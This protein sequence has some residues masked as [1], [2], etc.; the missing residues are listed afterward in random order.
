MGKKSN[1]ECE[2]LKQN[3]ANAFCNECKAMSDERRNINLKGLLK[4]FKHLFKKLHKHEWKTTHVNGFGMATEQRCNCGAI[5]HRRLNFPCFEEE[6]KWYDGE[7]DIEE[8][9]AE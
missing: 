2:K 4:Y 8:R 3:N 7:R 1:N 9:K 6:N 5:R